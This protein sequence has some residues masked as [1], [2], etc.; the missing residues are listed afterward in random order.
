MATPEKQ[1]MLTVSR[2]L[3]G[4]FILLAGWLDSSQDYF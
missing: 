1:A 4:L 3:A 2:A